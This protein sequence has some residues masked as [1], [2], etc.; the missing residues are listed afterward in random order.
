MSS[1]QC[2]V[3]RVLFIVCLL[4]VGLRNNSQQI[5]QRSIDLR[6]T[7]Q[8]DQIETRDNGH[9]T[10]DNRDKTIETIEQLNLCERIKTNQ[11]TNSEFLYHAIKFTLYF[12]LSFFSF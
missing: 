11:Q 2:L 12:S 9:W 5:G 3:S 10:I 1:V 7:E 8:I 6:G 4:N